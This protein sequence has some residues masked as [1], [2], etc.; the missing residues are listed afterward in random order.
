MPIYLAA[1]YRPHGVYSKA[2]SIVALHNL[3]HQGVFPPA[4]FADLGLPDSWWGAVDWQYPPHLRQGAYHE[5]G[6]AVNTL[7]GAIVTCDRLVTVSP[8]YAEVRGQQRIWP[9]EEDDGG[10]G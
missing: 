4:S 6:H 9:A 8:T 2:R 1:N 5:Q 3:R 7:K 10:V